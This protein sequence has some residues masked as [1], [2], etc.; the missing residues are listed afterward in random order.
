MFGLVSLPMICQSLYLDLVDLH[1]LSTSL[2]KNSFGFIS[3]AACLNDRYSFPFTLQ[4]GVP[5]FISSVA[6]SGLPFTKI[7]IF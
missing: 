7:K 1:L 5:P 4:I 2:P 3:I 6:I